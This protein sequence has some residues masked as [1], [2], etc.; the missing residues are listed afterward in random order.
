M[1]EL[2][3]E[4]VKKTLAD[5]NDPILDKGLVSHRFFKSAT[6]DGGKVMN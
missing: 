3:P 5:I 1:S 4:L 6:V 2:S